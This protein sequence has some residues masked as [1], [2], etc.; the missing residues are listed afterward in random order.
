[1]LSDSC[2]PPSPGWPSPGQAQ[3]FLRSRLAVLGQRL[4]GGL[5]VL[6]TACPTHARACPLNSNPRAQV[7]PPSLTI[8]PLS[9]AVYYEQKPPFN[10]RSLLLSPYGIMGGLM[11][12]AL[13]VVPR[14]KV[15]PEEYAALLEEQKRE[16]EARR[17]QRPR[18]I[19]R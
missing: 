8:P 3:C 18:A 11:L 10:L 5:A 13:V 4:S 1:M 16:E 7:L 2:L 15:D 17:Q 6:H 14:L 12:F 9:R 19:R